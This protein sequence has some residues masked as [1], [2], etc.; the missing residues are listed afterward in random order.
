MFNTFLFSCLPLIY[1]ESWAENKSRVLK[2]WNAQRE[3]PYTGTYHVILLFLSKITPQSF[4]WQDGMEK[5]MLP[6]VR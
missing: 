4:Q 2:E 3:C 5:R 6:V 1:G